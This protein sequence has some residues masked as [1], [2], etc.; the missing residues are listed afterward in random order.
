[1][2]A[3]CCYTCSLQRQTKKSLF[4]NKPLKIYERYIWRKSLFKCIYKP[5]GDVNTAGMSYD[6]RG[7][8]P[9]PQR[10]QLT[11]NWSTGDEIPTTVLTGLFTEPDTTVLISTGR[12]GKSQVAPGNIGNE[13]TYQT[14]SLSTKGSDRGGEQCCRDCPQA[15]QGPGRAARVGP[16][17]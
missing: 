16:D 6:H 5:E 10:Y 17:L 2:S 14:V 1:M 7:E 4:R 9:I 12:A 15:W 13:R 11:P 3:T 8:D